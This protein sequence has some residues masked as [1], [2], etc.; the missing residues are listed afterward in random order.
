MTMEVMEVTSVAPSLAQLCAIFHPIQK[1]AFHVT[2]PMREVISRE[3]YMCLK[4]RFASQTQ[5]HSGK[6]SLRK[7]FR[8]VLKSFFRA[9]SE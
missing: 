6:C 1:S 3:L 4:R 5:P 2:C 8:S 9:Y 7:C